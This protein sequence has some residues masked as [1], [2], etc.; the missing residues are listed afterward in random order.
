[1]REPVLREMSADEYLAWEQTQRERYELHHGF[2]FAF[3]GGTFDHDQIAFALRVALGEMFPA[4]CRTFGSDVKIRVA[5]E[6]FFYADVG[7]VCEPVE[8]RALFV[9]RPRI[10]AE[11]LSRSTRGYDLVEKRSAYRALPSV[12]AYIV[13]HTAMRRVEVDGRVGERWE[14][15]TY[16]D[17]IAFV[18][19]RP[20]SL[21]QVYGLP[22]DEASSG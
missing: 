11:V 7:V 19:T 2:A 14:T 1:M 20:V 15:V 6:T 8:G 12:E 9:E 5:S 10:V 4:P 22:S 17:E 16:D 3:A 21:E 13:V 18:G